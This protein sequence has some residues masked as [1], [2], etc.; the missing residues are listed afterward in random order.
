MRLLQVCESLDILCGT[1]E[2][3]VLEHLL[4]EHVADDSAH[5]CA[6]LL[7][8]DKEVFPALHASWATGR[9]AAD[10]LGSL[11]WYVAE[12]VEVDVSRSEVE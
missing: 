12:P 9:N 10:D 5:Q 7:L 1:A 6:P 2:E 8:V 4:H 3:N 11:L